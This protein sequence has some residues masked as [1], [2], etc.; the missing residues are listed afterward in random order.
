MY[1]KLLGYSFFYPRQNIY[2]LM[3]FHQIIQTNKQKQIIS[4]RIYRYWY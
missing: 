4:L 1:I 2:L 3:Y